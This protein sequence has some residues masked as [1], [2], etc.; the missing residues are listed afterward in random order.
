MVEGVYIPA[1]HDGVV[2]RPGA[3]ERHHGDLVWPG[4][5]V[6]EGSWPYASPESCRDTSPGGIWIGPTG[7]EVLVCAGCGLDG[8]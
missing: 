8:T 4:R 6:V 3:V 7:S 1:S 2:Y 5:L